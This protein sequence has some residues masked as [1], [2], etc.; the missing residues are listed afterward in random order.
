MD[1][2]KRIQKQFSKPDENESQ[3]VANW[4][5]KFQSI[6]RSY[7]EVLSVLEY[8]EAYLKEEF[9]SLDLGF[10]WI[11]CQKIRLE[12][13]KYLIRAQYPDDNIELAVDDCLYRFFMEYNSLIRNLFLDDI[14]ESELSALYEIFFSPFEGK[15]IDNILKFVD[16]H[17]KLCPTIYIEENKFDTSIY[18]LRVGLGK[19]ILID[20]QKVL[21]SRKIEQHEKHDKFQV[22]TKKPEPA[23]TAE[24]N[25]TQIEKM[26]R[27]YCFNEKMPDPKDI[28]IAISA[29]LSSY[30]RF[31][32]FY[33]FNDF[34]EIMI[35]SL[36]EYIYSGLMD[37]VKRNH[38]VEDLKTSISET[39]NKNVSKVNDNSLD[40]LAWKNDL[41]PILER[42]L[43]DFLGIMFGQTLKVKPQFVSKVEKVEDD[44]P[45]DINLDAI[46]DLKLSEEEFREK[47]EKLLTNKGVGLVQRRN[48]ARNKVQEFIEFKRLGGK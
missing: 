48:I 43:K 15:K 14:H 11:R 27:T 1:N 36:V 3:I 29:F 18:T 37:K 12:Y 44:D 25:G 9:T 24:F 6:G 8:Y 33:H 38:L 32:I 30:F 5:H 7:L 31:G 23:K 47:L 46:W 42:I 13:K 40:G 39:I 4:L 21:N 10:E 20:Y 17:T 2:F 34:K 41:M 28:E 22:A 26:I 45:L 19:L 16:T 35:E